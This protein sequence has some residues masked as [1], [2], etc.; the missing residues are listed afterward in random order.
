MSKWQEKILGEVVSFIKGK[1]TKQSE[2]PKDG[3]LPLINTDAIKGKFTLFAESNG[4]T[5]CRESDVLM[6]WDGERSGLVAIGKEGVVGSTFAKLSSIEAIDSKYLYYYLDNKFEWIQQ[7]RTGT[8][9][10]HVPKDLDRILW[11]KYPENKSTQHRIARILSTTDTV[12]E[13]TKAAIAKY[14]AIKQGMLHDLFTRGIVTEPT[15]YKDKTGK[16]VELRRNQL[17]P[18]Y[19]DAPELYKESNLGWIPKEWEEKIIENVGKVNG[20]VGWKGY[21]ISDLRE[22]GPLAL[23][24]A[25]ID[26]ENKLDLTNPIHLSMEKYLESPEI[27]VQSGDILVV[28]RGTIGKIM[29]INREIGEATINPSMVLINNLRI[30][31]LFLYYQMVSFIVQRQIENLTSQTGVPMISQEQIN[32]I[33]I[34]VPKDS[35]ETDLITERMKVIDNKIQTEQNYLRKLQQIKAGLMADLLSGK[36]EVLLMKKR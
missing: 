31:S 32:N 5:I 11:F 28:Q 24:A 15:S 17:R 1:L 16:V 25:H 18:K 14:K 20:R 6:L 10:P 34:V 26:K 27:M 12:I 23:G 21:T 30:N 22:F 29:I 7:Q 19:Q 35:N 33:K 13:K 3:F 9:V 36:K 8:G 4:A 2:F